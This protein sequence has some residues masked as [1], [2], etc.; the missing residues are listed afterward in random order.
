[1]VVPAGRMM[2]EC[3][4]WEEPYSQGFQTTFLI[5]LLEF[6][7]IRGSRVSGPQGSILS[8]RTPQFPSFPT[9]HDS[10]E[11][12]PVTTSCSLEEEL[13]LTFIKCIFIGHQLFA[14]EFPLTFLFPHLPVFSSPCKSLLLELCHFFCCFVLQNRLWVPWTN[15][16]ILWW[17]FNLARCVKKWFKFNLGSR[18]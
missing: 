2:M 18:S 8:H 5:E 16:M 12:H 3:K 7:G 17:Y 1:M 6:C 9:Q 10:L 4:N 14:R 11:P 15:K 13:S